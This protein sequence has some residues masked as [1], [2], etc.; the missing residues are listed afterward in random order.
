MVALLLCAF[1]WSHITG[2]SITFGDSFAALVIGLF[3]NNVLP[4]RL[5]EVARGYVLTKR[6]GISLTYALSTVLVDRYFD[7]MGLLLLAVIFYPKESLPPSVSRGIVVLVALL[8][9]CIAT[10]IVMSRQR[11]AHALA[12]RLEQT[13]RPLCMRIARRLTE[14]QENLKRIHSPLTFLYLM[15]ISF[16][17]WFSMSLSL[18]LVAAMLNVRV[19]FAVIPFVCALLNVGLTVP[20]S[21]GY[22]GVYQ[23]LIIYLLAIFGVPKEQGFAVSVLYHALWYFPYNVMGFIYSIKEHLKVTELSRLEEKAE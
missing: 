11:F 21:P 22:V 18:Y 8:A 12:A 7:L 10:F 5:G 3:V 23:F 2:P 19:A 13:G 9:F 15:A 20:S 16:A 17:I 4:A 1:R 14:I 6:R